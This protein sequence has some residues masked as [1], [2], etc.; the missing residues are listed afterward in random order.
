M[1]LSLSLNLYLY[2]TV[3]RTCSRWTVLMTNIQRWRPYS[4]VAAAC[5]PKFSVCQCTAMFSVKKKKMIIRADEAGASN[6]DSVTAERFLICR[7]RL[8]HA[9]SRG[10]RTS[11]HLCRRKGGKEGQLASAMRQP[12]DK[13]NMNAWDSQTNERGRRN[14]HAGSAIILRH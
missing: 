9:P 3:W 10:R 6:D 11:F 1:E 12:S 4:T 14:V 8:W 2:Y 13:Q 7:I 5:L